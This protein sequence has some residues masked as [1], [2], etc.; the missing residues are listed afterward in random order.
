MLEQK[1]LKVKLLIPQSNIDI[2]LTC[3]TFYVSKKNADVF[4]AMNVDS[5]K[6]IWHKRPFIRFRSDVFNY[7]P[8]HEIR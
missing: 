8:S 7:F 6:L 1:R 4:V 3:K 5:V 2:L